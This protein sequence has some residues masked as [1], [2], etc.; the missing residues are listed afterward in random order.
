MA[1]EIKF[2]RKL[3]ASFND[4]KYIEGLRMIF[5]IER[6]A[7]DAFAK[8][9]LEIYNMSL[10]N[11][12]EEESIFKEGD[13]VSLEG[14]YIENESVLFTGSIKNIQTVRQGVDTITTVF[15]SDLNSSEE[16]IINSSYRKQI[17]LIS[18]ISDI[19]FEADIDIAEISIK[20]Q[21]LKSSV[22]Y[23]KKFSS[24]L[25][26]LGETYNFGWY[27]YNFELYLYDNDSA[28]ST[29]AILNINAKTGLLESPV[30]TQKGIDV[31]MLL[32]PSIRQKDRYEVQSG[33]LQFSQGN[34]ELVESITQGLGVQSV[35]SVVHTG[36]THG[37]TWFTE[38]EGIKMI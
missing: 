7:G 17:S 6:V 28:N 38:I 33:G 3:K 8:L 25:D 34:L 16:P 5:R 2:G 35:L 1:S 21:N 4:G 29:N 20:S 26:E 18:L 22:T 14:G 10:K 36:D 9:K 32:E 19:A 27:I 31:K 15:A 11:E 30:L 23:S 12:G 13:K 37:T 24:I